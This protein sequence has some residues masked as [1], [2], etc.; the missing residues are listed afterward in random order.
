MNPPSV[1]PPDDP[2]GWTKPSIYSVLV[3]AL[4]LG[5]LGWGIHLG[6]LSFTEGLIGALI[7]IVTWV[8][9]GAR[10]PIANKIGPTPPDVPLPQLITP[11][12]DEGAPR[13]QMVTPRNPPSS[14]PGGA[15]RPLRLL[16]RLAPRL[17]IALSGA[18]VLAACGHGG[19]VCAVIDLAHQ[20]C[21]VVRYLETDGTMREVRLT[22]EDAR[23][24][25]RT[26]AAK[27]AERDG[28]AEGGLK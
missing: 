6:K 4:V 14:D 26:A 1:T 3:I 2:D 28:G 15:S 21:T 18:A 20:T 27:S 17:A 8:T 5:L 12:T 19:Q 16:F 10:P 22:P 25:A 11:I 7:G 23:D 13:D 24:F 9:K